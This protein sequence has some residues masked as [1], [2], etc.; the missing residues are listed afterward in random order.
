MLEGLRRLREL[1]AR[2]A[3]VTSSANNLA[4]IR[5]Y[6]SVGFGIAD[7]EQFYRAQL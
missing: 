1:G 7:R 2:R 4:S 5:L 6:E 3:L